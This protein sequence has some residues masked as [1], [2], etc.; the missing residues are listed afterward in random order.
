[1]AGVVVVAGAVG[2]RPGVAVGPGV[3]VGRAREVQTAEA[4]A[5]DARRRA[6]RRLRRA[7]VGR[8]VGRHR[9]G[10]VG[11]ADDVGD[12]AA[13]VVVVAGGVG[14][15]PGVAVGPGVG[16][17]RAREVQAAEALA[18]DAGRRAGRRLRRARVGHV[19]GRHRNVGVGLAG[20]F[21]DRAA[22][23]V[24]VAGAVGE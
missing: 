21:G 18:Q 9:D 4:L 5:Q 20:R 7:R 13:G 12:A 8:V 16:V 14:E 6:G 3:G 24:V 15:R 17:A 19:V 1:A 11:L 10:G 2:E 22:G 23:V